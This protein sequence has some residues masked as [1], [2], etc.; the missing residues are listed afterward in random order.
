MDAYGVDNFSF[1]K[2]ILS[3][4]RL[5]TTSA[6]ALGKFKNRGFVVPASIPLQLSSIS[7]SYSTIRGINLVSELYI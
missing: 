4:S 1:G 5:I 6:L 7:M 3:L 2:S